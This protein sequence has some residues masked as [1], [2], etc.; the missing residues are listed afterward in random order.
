MTPACAPLQSTAHVVAHSE[1]GAQIKQKVTM[2]TRTRLNLLNYPVRITISIMG[3]VGEAKRQGAL[4]KP[5]ACF[6]LMMKRTQLTL[7][8]KPSGAQMQNPMSLSRMQTLSKAQAQSMLRRLQSQAGQ[9]VCSIVGG[10]GTHSTTTP[11][12]STSGC[13]REWPPKL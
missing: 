2:K 3:K 5:P 4:A 13:R 11:I 9:I 7:M 12:C 1:V 8:S 6:L 10:T